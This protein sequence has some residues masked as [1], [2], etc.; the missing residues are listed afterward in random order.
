MGIGKEEYA[1]MR[2]VGRGS[3]GGELRGEK[4]VT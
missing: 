4:A 3:P 1:Y 2:G